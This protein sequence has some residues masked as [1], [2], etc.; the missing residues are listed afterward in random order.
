MK[1]KMGRPLGAVAEVRKVRIAY[2]IDQ[3]VVDILNAVA[4][5]GRMTKTKAIEDAI[6][7]VF[8]PE[9]GPASGE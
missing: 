7:R 1:K 6:R 8:G 2:R 5:T 4:E 3:D 9:F